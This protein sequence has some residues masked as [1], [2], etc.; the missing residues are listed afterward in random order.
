MVCGIHTINEIQCGKT[1]Y[2]SMLMLVLLF[3]VDL[4]MYTAY[5]VGYMRK[6]NNL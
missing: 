2:T 6:F 4:H 1:T 3:D 5:R